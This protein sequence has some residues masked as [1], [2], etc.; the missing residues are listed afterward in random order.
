MDTFVAA[1]T[2]KFLMHA[3]GLDFYKF[4]WHRGTSRFGFCSYRDSTISLS[5]ELVAVSSEETVRNTILHEI[6]HALVGPGHSHDS[7]WRRQFIAL[8]GNGERTCGESESVRKLREEKAK[9]S[10]KCPD[11]GNVFFAQKRLSNFDKRWC[12]AKPC[13]SRN[14]VAETRKY[15]VWEAK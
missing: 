13:A 8:G 6:A 14:K 7:V 10:A 11:C 2:A 9:W 1:S 15:L 4:K 3:H 5:E 12:G